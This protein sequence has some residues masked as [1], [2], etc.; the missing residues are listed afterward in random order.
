MR[1]NATAEREG[2]LNSTD[3]FAPTLNVCQFNANFSMP[4]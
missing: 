2:W 4:G 1:F 3:S